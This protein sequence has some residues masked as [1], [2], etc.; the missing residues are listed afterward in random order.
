L[1]RCKS[2]QFAA[3]RATRFCW[4]C[5]PC[6]RDKAGDH[7]CLR[8]LQMGC[9]SLDITTWPGGRWR[10]SAFPNERSARKARLVSPGILF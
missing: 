6:H 2:A 3:T 10:K 1:R 5:R 8:R 7:R 4:P 9:A